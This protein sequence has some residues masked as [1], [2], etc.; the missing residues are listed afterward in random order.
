MNI[1]GMSLPLRIAPEPLD[2]DFEVESELPPLVTVISKEDLHKMKPKERK[3]KRLSTVRS[4]SGMISC[5]A[6]IISSLFV[7]RFFFFL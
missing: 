7:F 1:S 4:T 6:R 2:S 5:F 3:D